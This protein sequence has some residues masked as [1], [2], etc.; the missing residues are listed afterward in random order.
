MYVASMFPT[1]KKYQTN[2]TLTMYVFP[3]FNKYETRRRPVHKGG[4]QPDRVLHPYLGNFCIG[5][6]KMGA[7]KGLKPETA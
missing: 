7:W 5:W 6:V 4:V 3:K 2:I 1:Y